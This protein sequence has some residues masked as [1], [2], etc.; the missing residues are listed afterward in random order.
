MTKKNIFLLI[1]ISLLLIFIVFCYLKI[2]KKNVI[3]IEATPTHYSLNTNDLIANFMVDE[4]VTNKKFEGKIIEV[5]GK[6]KEISFLNNTNS[7]ILF[8]VDNSGV[9]CDFNK[10]QTE[11]IKKLTKNQTVKIKGIYKGY[12]KDVILLNCLLMKDKTNE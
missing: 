4:K 6:I 10:N 5:E 1:L 2:T 7:V 9:I 8:G 11:E 3:N 12:L